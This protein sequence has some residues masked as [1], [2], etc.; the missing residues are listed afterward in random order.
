MNL[1]VAV[2]VPWC[3]SYKQPGWDWDGDGENGDRGD[4]SKWCALADAGSS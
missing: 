3:I 1:E 4:G 2:S